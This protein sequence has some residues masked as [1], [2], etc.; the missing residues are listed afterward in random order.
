[1]KI[2]SVDDSKVMRKIIAKATAVLGYDVLEAANGQAAFDLLESSHSEIGLILLDWNMPEM[3]GLT[4]L[5]K[6]KADER[7]RHLP[8]MMVTSESDRTKMVQAIRAGAS[9]Y[10]T[11]P[12]TQEELEMKIAS[13]LGESV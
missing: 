2:L 8:V 5:A 4:F 9:N 6:V 1:M 10:L 3:D 11:K 7:F 12:F 13:C